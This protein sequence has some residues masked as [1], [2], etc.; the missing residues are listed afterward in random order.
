MGSLFHFSG[1]DFTRVCVVELIW[2][3]LCALV[4]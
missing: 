1:F 4:N 3:A 2:V